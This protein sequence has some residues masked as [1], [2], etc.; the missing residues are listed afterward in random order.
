MSNHFHSSEPP[1][2]TAIP[3]IRN[4]FGVSAD[5]LGELR[6]WLEQNPPAIPVD[7]IIGLNA[8]TQAS[9]VRLSAN[10]A[11]GSSTVTRTVVAFDTVDFDFGDLFDSTSH[12]YTIKLAGKYLIAASLNWDTSGAGSRL[13]GIRLNGTEVLENTVKPVS[14]YGTI[15]GPTGILDLKVGDVIDCVGM[16]NVGS[17]LNIVGGAS[18]LRTNMSI[19]RIGN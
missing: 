2:S 12:A 7:Q 10:Q 18:D 17:N 16:Q 19:A 13:A 6:T 9:R 1:N 4:I 11:L 15:H 14:D 3:V 8:S 5:F